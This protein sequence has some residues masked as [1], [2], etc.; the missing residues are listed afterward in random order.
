MKMIE[1]FFFSV[2]NGESLVIYEKL[3]FFS[4]I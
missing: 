4:S 3:L 2:E 1:D